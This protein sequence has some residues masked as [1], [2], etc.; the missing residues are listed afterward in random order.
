MEWEASPSSCLL[1]SWKIVKGHLAKD[2]LQVL[3]INDGGSAF[4]PGGRGGEEREKLLAAYAGVINFSWAAL[5]MYVPVPVLSPPHL[6]T[7]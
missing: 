2:C 4:F 1:H 7:W 3:E 6:T 5:T